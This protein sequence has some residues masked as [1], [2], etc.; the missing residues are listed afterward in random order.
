MPGRTPLHLPVLSA[1]VLRPEFLPPNPKCSTD[2]SG[3]PDPLPPSDDLDWGQTCFPC[4]LSWRS[5][6]PSAQRVFPS[7]FPAPPP[8]LPLHHAALDL[9]TSLASMSV[10]S[11]WQNCYPSSRSISLF[12]DCT[13]ECVDQR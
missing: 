13:L 10:H 7:A 2:S 1:T 6:L 9:V 8:L 12:S 11:S 5:L 4:H 3:L